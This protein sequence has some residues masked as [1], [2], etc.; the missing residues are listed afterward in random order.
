[1]ATHCYRFD[2]PHR[3]GCNFNIWTPKKS[4]CSYPGGWSKGYL[5]AQNAI[6]Q[7]H[8]EKETAAGRKPMPFD[9]YFENW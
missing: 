2:C 9:A 4:P 7:E 1:M 6:Y 5:S 3:T 8:V